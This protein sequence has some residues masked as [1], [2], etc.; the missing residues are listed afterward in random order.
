MPVVTMP[1]Q[2]KQKPVAPPIPEAGDDDQDSATVRV[3]AEVWRMCR[4]LK[5][6]E[7]GKPT[8]L[9]LIDWAAL[10]NLRVRFAP[11]EA[12]VTQLEREEEQARLRMDEIRRA[13]QAKEKSE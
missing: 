4:W 8:P 9:Q 2:K 12:M 6:L 10:D 7:R 11:Y 1:P 3:S 5:K 13:M